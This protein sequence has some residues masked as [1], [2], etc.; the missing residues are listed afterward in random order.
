MDK[1]VQK[2]SFGLYQGGNLPEYLKKLVVWI[3][4]L[5]SKITKRT[6]FLLGY[7][8]SAT[9]NPG[10][11]ANG[12]QEVKDVTVNGAV[13]GD[14]ALASFSL[15][16]TDLQLTAAVTATNTATCVLSN[17]TGLSVNI[18]EGTIRVWVV[19]K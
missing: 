9:W 11:I 15:D 5:Y 13:I 10:A 19:S 3:E 12:S 6:N 1:L 17:M 14:F 18:A 7:S 8:G 16:V 4:N 2:E